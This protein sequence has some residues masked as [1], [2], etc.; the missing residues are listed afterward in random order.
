MQGLLQPPHCTMEFLAGWMR[1]LCAINDLSPRRYVQGL[2]PHLD[3]LAKAGTPA[4]CLASTELQSALAPVVQA[5]VAHMAPKVLE[6][7]AEATD[8]P[9]AEWLASV[10]K[11]VAWAEDIERHDPPST[12]MRRGC[13]GEAAAGRSLPTPSTSMQGG[14]LGGAAAGG[15]L[16]PPSPSMQGGSLGGAAAGGPL[17][18]PSPSMQGGSLGGTAAGGPLPPPSTFMQGGSLGGAAAEI[19]KQHVLKSAILQLK[20]HEAT[21]EVLLSEVEMALRPKAS[22]K[23]ELAMQ[24]EPPAASEPAEQPIS[25]VRVGNAAELTRR[26]RNQQALSG[27]RASNL[28]GLSGIGAN[29]V[30]QSLLASLSSQLKHIMVAVLAAGQG[31]G[32]VGG[33]CVAPEAAAA[34]VLAARQGGGAGGGGAAGRSS[35]TGAG[36]GGTQGGTQAHVSSSFGQMATA[37][38]AEGT[39]LTSLFS[40]LL[41]EIEQQNEGIEQTNLLLRQLV[42]QQSHQG[43]SVPNSSAGPSVTELEQPPRTV[44]PNGPPPPKVNPSTKRKRALLEV[45]MPLLSVRLAVSFSSYPPSRSPRLPHACHAPP[46]SFPRQAWLMSPRTGLLS[47]LLT[48][49]LPRPSSRPSSRQPCRLQPRP[50]PRPRVQGSRW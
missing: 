26:V 14:S 30:T 39:V 41:K 6:V 7:L 2:P 3:T 46:P 22:I 1:H 4:Q 49:S 25:G 31:G 10:D 42:S 15:P 38:A 13:L 43:D 20:A 9:R 21:L 11:L 5:L 8:R 19:F 48:W 16:P 32:A 17:P 36:P 40:T 47:S 35:G 33:A 44:Q 23:T 24:P 28:T 37:Q 45:S 12:S 50:R 34:A 27:V 29:S 18:P